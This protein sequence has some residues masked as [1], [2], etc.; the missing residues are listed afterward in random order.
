MNKA[1]NI[2]KKAQNQGVKLELKEGSLVLKSENEDIDDALINEIR[3]HKALI[4]ECLNKF[5]GAGTSYKRLEQDEIKPFDRGLVERIP[6]SFSQE[7]L[8]FID[9]LKGSLEYHIPVA[10]RLSGE[11]NKK[12][13]L[14]SLREIVDRHEILRTVIYSEEGIGYQRVLPAGDWDLSIKNITF[15]GLLLKEDLS[16]FLSAPFDLSA[17]YMFRSCLYDLG[18][19]EYL[20]AGVF[21]HIS[22]DGWSK[23]ILVREFV[24]LYDAHVSGSKV[25][26]PTLPLQYMDYAVWQRNHL[27]GAYIDSELSYW[28]EKLAG[29]NDLQLP[30]DYVRPAVQSGSGKTISLELK[31]TLSTAITSLS[32]REGTTVFMTLLAAFK[33]LMSRYSGQED[34]CVGTPVA[35]RTQK[36][37]EGVIGFFVNTLALRTQ[38][39]E[40]SSFQKLLQDVKKTTLEAYD[41]Q[42]VPFESVVDRVVKTR[43][44]SMNPLFQVLFALQNT[45]DSDQIALE[46][47]MISKYEEYE[48]DASKFDL[49]IQINEAGSVFSVEINY[50]TDLFKEAT[51]QRMLVHYQ[52]LLWSVIS[53]PSTQLGK[54]SMLTKDERHQLLEVF[55]DTSVDYPKDKTLINLFERQV[56]KTPDAIAVAFKDELLTYQQLDERS[57]QLAHF[58]ND[59]GVGLENAVGVCLER[60][61]ELII[62]ILGVLKSGGAYVPIDPEHPKER[63]QYMLEDASIMLL[64]S[65]TS[66]FERLLDLDVNELILF[67]A[68]SS[69][70]EKE[71]TTPLSISLSASHLAYIIYTSGSTGKPKGVLIEHGGIC[72]TIQGQISVFSISDTDHCLQYA[73]TSFDASI[74][75]I[76]LSLLAGARLCIIDESKKYEIDYFFK[77]VEDQAITFSIL[78][79]AFFELLD[80]SQIP[81]IKT[82]VTGGEEAPL[83]NA[84]SFSKAGN[85]F[86]AYGP[87]EASI[88]AT[89]FNGKIDASV[90]IG[91]P[92][93]NTTVYLL[94][95]ASA[96]VPIGAV[97][98]L[99]V[100]G[101]GLAR[102]YLNQE[103]LTAQQFVANP[104]R[105][106]ERLY[107]T[108]DLGR[109][110]PDG[111]IEFIGRKDDQVKIRGYRIELGEIEKTLSMVPGVQ[112]CC[113]VAREDHHGD[114]HLMAY[115][116]TAETGKKTFLQE[117]LLQRLPKYMVPKLWVRL[118]ELPLTSSGKVDRKSLP[119][120]EGSALSN[121]AYVAP[122][123]KTEVQLASIWQDLLGIEKVG[124]HDDFFELG[125]HSLMAVRLVSMI[126][127]EMEIE[128]AIQDIFLHTTIDR[129]GA[130][131]DV[132]D[133]GTAV[134]KVT[135]AEQRPQ[136]VPLSFS[137]ESLWLID[138]LQGSLEYNLSFAFQIA[139]DLNVNALSRSLQ[140]V[141]RRHNVLRTVIYSEEGEGYQKV[142][143]A[144]KWELSIKDAGDDTSLFTEDLKAFLS[145]PF[146]LGADY[147]FRSCL[148][149]LGNK[150]YV[151]AGVFHHISSD[152]WSKGILIKEFMA[153]YSG[154]VSG[155]QIDLPSLPLQYVDY[156]LW[157]RNYLD[158]AIIDNQ[159]SYW[160]DKLDGFSKLQLSTDYDR[161]AV[162]SIS[163]STISFQ[164]SESLASGIRSL[165]YRESATVF[166]TLLAAFKVLLSRYSGQEDICV[167]TSVA[168]RTQKELE[169]MIGYFVN[170]LALRTQID[171]TDS[172]QKLLQNVR[173]T[174]LEAYDHQQVP[175]EKVIERVLNT[176][177]HSGNPLFR[178][179]FVLQNTPKS[180]G[181]EL[182]G[183][184]LSDYEVDIETTA[185]FDLKMTVDEVETDFFIH[186]NYATD[187]FKE[188]T[189]QRMVVHY[190]ELLE[191]IV[192]LPSSRLCD[193]SM[194]PGEE[195]HQL[196]EVF[197]GTGISL[198]T[199]DQTV[200]DLFE[201]QAEKTPDSVAIVY[202]G[203]TLSY[204]QLN[205]RSNQLA[206]YLGS[207]GVT[208][209]TLV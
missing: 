178:V 170:V 187:L 15:D 45:P 10:L 26:L 80:V 59:K 97:G 168:N 16:A 145:A 158:G 55:N 116:V 101:L 67:D 142:L 141:V 33:V 117:Q 189:I 7:R 183:L 22:S 157:Q 144:E 162:Q 2:I 44:M 56:G 171:E 153:L 204:Q 95:E 200:I 49:A 202:E 5:D 179:L 203:D 76:F 118:D 23:A 24:A 35:N 150:D 167:G 109:W 199:S 172:F 89:I 184:T 54:L 85:Y 81:S 27:E 68:A 177:D 163:G 65:T 82:L 131:L 161:P 60:S 192:Q 25:S 201:E 194:L 128:L 132:Q 86:N 108:G 146:D 32:Q 50:C 143:S 119:E 39:T 52:E 12:A 41:H 75:E 57:N 87:T 47:L 154:C 40:A 62:S 1:L 147:M 193:L 4:I 160:E 125:G 8:W 66:V 61:A 135:T 11:L 205:E 111:S 123:T 175:L 72:N 93:P 190:Q 3:N 48:E 99:C 6:L 115:F 31:N 195:R 156:A 51:I 105:E 63:I 38:V 169:G 155:K 73:N 13:L 209:D 90:P 70:I 196:L 46:G 173:Q 185:N 18:D 42:Q 186:L 127:K 43:D 198:S 104:F 96:L 165:S 98:E 136:K 174:T 182:E 188:A 180:K 126:R 140:A 17:D 88:C 176:R 107:K 106:G 197:N 102:G 69:L 148:Y 37:L 100:G 121:S 120:P 74:W 139:G 64:L 19:Q 137:Q 30:T 78:P 159:L 83:K 112:Q 14:S 28:E 134:P 130:Y 92:V 36:E 53:S 71:S 208:S 77:F 79:P 84:K 21:H 166:M 164:L 9:Q 58:L 129:L 113:I 207:K 206:R 20:L 91:S 181:V 149:D 122:G 138:Q 124:I 152:A 133:K 94:N 103:A 110:L 191:G 114:K 151:L 34:V 29:V